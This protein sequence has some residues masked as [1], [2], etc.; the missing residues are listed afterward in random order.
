MK[1]TKQ[2]QDMKTKSENPPGTSSDFESINESLLRQGYVRKDA[3]IS[4]VRA[5]VGALLYSLPII[6]VLILIFLA[7][8]SGSENEYSFGLINVLVFFVL[9][10]VSVPV[11]ELLHGLGWSL[12][13]ENG[14]K[15]IKFGVLKESF[16]PYCHCKKPLPFGPYAFGG[17]LPFLIL[18]LVI[19][20]IALATGDI[21]ILAL[22]AFNILA[23]G[24]DLMIAVKLIGYRNYL[25][26][27]HPSEC[28]FIAYRKA[29]YKN[30]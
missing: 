17:V 20:C 30:A 10:L 7:V 2:E 8:H 18:G 23:A 6:V 12:F 3:T 16:T 26:V 28:G 21:F 25:I 27:D 15:D 14:F 13:S 9:M 11:H 22:S 5:N 24:G 4:I 1:L 29:E 19:Y